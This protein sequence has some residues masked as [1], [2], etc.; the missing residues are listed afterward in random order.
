MNYNRIPPMI[1]PPPGGVIPPMI[2][3]PPMGGC[4]VPFFPPIPPP[5]FPGGLVGE[6][7]SCNR[8]DERGSITANVAPQ[9]VPANSTTPV[10]L[11]S[12]SS[13]VG[14]MNISGNSIVLGCRGRYTISISI[15]VS[16]DALS[17]A[18]TVSFLL[19]GG[20]GG[21]G[22]LS[23]MNLPSGSTQVF[24]GSTTFTTNGRNES[25]SILASNL[26]GLVQILGGTITVQLQDCERRRCNDRRGR[27]DPF[28]F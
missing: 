22:T 3:I 19:N 1:P 26:G 6:N 28:I 17:A 20:V 27:V 13:S 11:A 12:A 2:G 21:S 7:I 24:T 25:V 15:T 14:D 8:R 4:N 18:G 10:L 23:S 5:L 9:S 16:R